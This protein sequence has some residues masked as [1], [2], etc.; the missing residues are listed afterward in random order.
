MKMRRKIAFFLILVLVLQMFAASFAV[1]AA[2]RAGSDLLDAYTTADAK[3]YILSAIDYY[4]NNNRNLSNGN[5]RVIFMF[6]GANKN[7][8][9]YSDKRDQAITVVLETATANIIY[10]QDNCSTIP[11]KPDGVYDGLPAAT[12]KDGTYPI[13]TINHGDHG[14][15]GFG[16]KDYAA[17]ALNNDDGVPCFR[18][19]YESSATLI[20]IH[21]REDN[22]IGSDKPNSTGCL[23]VGTRD[24]FFSFV[25]LITGRNF[26]SKEDRWESNALNK[27]CGWVV[28]DRQ[29]A[30]DALSTFYGSTI[31]D[32]TEASWGAA[33]EYSSGSSDNG[34]TDNNTNN[35][36]TVSS[37][38]TSTPTTSSS[39]V[40]TGL[41]YVTS[42][43]NQLRVRAGASKS[44]T[45]LGQLPKDAY[46]WVTSTTVKTNDGYE[47]YKVVTR[48]MTGWVA[49]YNKS[50][51]DRNL[52]KSSK[53]TYACSLGFSRPANGAV[54][55]QGQ[56]YNIEG[57]V[58][59][60]SGSNATVR[61]MLSKLDG[62][63][64]KSVPITL[65]HKETVDLKYTD[66]NSK[67]KF[68]NLSGGAYKLTITVNYT[69][70][71]TAKSK[72]VTHTFTIG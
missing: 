12:V 5:G 43:G 39:S 72:T 20:H 25:N 21:S 36:G 11:D 40:K 4:L 51:G 34:G 44:S 56:P 22:S 30:K 31:N 18:Y 8:N 14:F 42:V 67:L 59:N 50:N 49:A 69:I 16:R 13:Y 32:I 19:N 66:I 45:I 47:W 37:S 54:L 68:G 6:E 17:F 3:K 41:Y 61:A 15:H 27:F 2:S 38:T 24:S 53:Y 9:S 71:G 7:A 48:G 64:Y 70:N 33:Y 28:I 29:L 23:L 62:S 1:S 46:V 10:V 63:Y 65:E 35:N 26:I 52:R 58:N 55:P 60:F 57:F